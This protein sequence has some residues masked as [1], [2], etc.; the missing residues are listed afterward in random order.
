M[1]LDKLCSNTYCY[2]QKGSYSTI[3]KLYAAMIL[4]ERTNFSCSYGQVRSVLS[5]IN[6]TRYNSKQ[7]CHTHNTQQLGFIP[8]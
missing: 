1:C 4:F 8:R 6:K 7:Y 2:L 5:A 3:A